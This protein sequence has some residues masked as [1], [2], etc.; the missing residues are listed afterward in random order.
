MERNVLADRE[1]VRLALDPRD[2]VLE[3]R[4]ERAHDEEPRSRS[5]PSLP[6]RAPAMITALSPG[7][8]ALGASSAA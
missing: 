6:S 1:A 7:Y 8:I 4:H 5:S 2:E 3:R